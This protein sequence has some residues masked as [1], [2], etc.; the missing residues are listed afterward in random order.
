MN[1]LQPQPISLQPSLH[2]DRH[3]SILSDDRLG[4]LV[5]IEEDS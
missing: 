3:S 5:A 4:V 1:N 2:S